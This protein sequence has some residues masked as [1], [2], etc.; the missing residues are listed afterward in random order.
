ME[1]P[2]TEARRDVERIYGAAERRLGVRARLDLHVAS[3]G[4]APPIVGKN[5]Y[6]EAF[7]HEVLPRVWVEVY[8]LDAT[9][10]EIAE[11]ACEELLHIKHPE[12]TEDEVGWMARRCAEE[13]LG[14]DV[15]RRAGF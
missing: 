2:E 13:L 11:V 7:P 9:D 3:V 6:G 5:V 12:K 1:D 10:R 8:P 14:E 4:V 15:L